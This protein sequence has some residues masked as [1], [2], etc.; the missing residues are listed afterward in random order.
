M[1]TNMT[2]SVSLSFTLVAFC[3]A[4]ITYSV[5]LLCRRF[6]SHVRLFD[7]FVR[8]MEFRSRFV[9]DCCFLEFDSSFKDCGA[10]I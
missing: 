7:E 4:C 9:E 5:W 6:E 3:C 1:R 8:M 2:F 10:G